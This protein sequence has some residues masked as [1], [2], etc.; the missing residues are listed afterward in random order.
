MGRQLTG[1]NTVAATGIVQAPGRHTWCRGAGPGARLHRRR[2]CT[3]AK[4][5]CPQ[6]QTPLVSSRYLTGSGRNR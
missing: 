5:V 4:T 1:Y 2:Q 6:L 3:L